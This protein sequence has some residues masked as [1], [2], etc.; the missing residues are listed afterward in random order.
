M[1][2][3][4]MI[5]HGVIGHGVIGHGVI[6]GAGE[7]QRRVGEPLRCDVE[8]LQ[9]ERAAQLPARRA[10]HGDLQQR[11]GHGARGDVPQALV[12]A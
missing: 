5:G 7:A 4:G 6:G 1:I 11:G 2:G 12:P 10:G 9:V 8:T 3:H